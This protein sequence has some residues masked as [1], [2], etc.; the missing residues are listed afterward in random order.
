MIIEHNKPTDDRL[1]RTLDHNERARGRSNNGSYETS[2]ELR[3]TS[4]QVRQK[5]LDLRKAFGS[6]DEN[7]ATFSKV[8]VDPNKPNKDLEKSKDQILE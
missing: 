3:E 6:S 2:K 8:L 4:S 5:E 7:L 1:K